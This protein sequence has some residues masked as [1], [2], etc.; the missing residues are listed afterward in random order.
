MNTRVRLVI[1]VGFAALVSLGCQKKED[2]QTTRDRSPPSAAGSASPPITGNAS[3]A[4]G[5]AAPPQSA[6][7]L[8][9]PL[10]RIDDVTITLGELQERIN[11]QSPYIRARYTSLEQKKEF[12]DSLIRFEVLAKEAYR[13]GL[14]KDP[15]VVRTMK[16]VMIQRLMRDEFDAKITADTVSDAEMKSYYDANLADYVK[17][18]EVRVSAIIVKN[19]AQAERVALEARGEAGK[20]NKGFRDLVSRYTQDEDSKLRGGDL[21]YFD[22][23]TKELPAPVVRAAFALLNTGDVSSA[24]DAG[25]GTWYVLKQTGRRKAM[26]KSFDDAKPAIRN[27]LFRDQRLAA[28]KDFVDGLKAAAKIEIDEANLAKVRIDTS[29]AVDD[30]HGRDLPAVPLAPPPVGPPGRATAPPE[31]PGFP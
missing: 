7:E 18:E 22:A 14:D 13:R 17:P 10:A 25:N 16:Q 1:L 12:L 8:R 20:T 5:P 26:T 11:R 29:Q 6:E 19:R 27:K 23:Q 2:P 4:G 24:I 30:G 28:Q 15:E 3:S 9:A 31:R 21:R